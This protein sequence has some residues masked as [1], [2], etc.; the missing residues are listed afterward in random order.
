[1]A[2]DVRGNP[3][4]SY[5]SSGGE[6]AWLK[7]VMNYWSFYDQMHPD[8]QLGADV[9]GWDIAN[10]VEK[11]QRQYGLNPT[12]QADQ[13]TWWAIDQLARGVPP[14]QIQLDTG[15]SVPN[16]GGPWS[17]SPVDPGAPG[18]SNPSMTTNQRDALARVTLLL[19]SYGLSGME[20]WIKSKLIGGASEA[21]ISLE[22]Y[23]QPAFKARFP[24]ID[25]RR[26]A[27]LSPVSAAEVIE[28]EQR[29]REIMRMAGITSGEF[30]TTSY[31]Q[32]LML[33]DVSA[34]E[35]NSRVQDG[36]VRVQSAPPE[37]KVAFGSY[38]GT[39]GD[40]AMAQLFLDP[41]IAVPELE[42]MA[43]TAMAGGI[44]ARFGLQLAQGI[45]REI[46]DTGASDQAIWQGFAALDNMKSIFRES[47]SEG[48]DLTAEGEGIGAVF[49]TRP[50][51]TATLEQR[52]N[53]RTSTFRGGGSAAASDQGIVG[54]GIAD[55]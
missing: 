30:T 11:F 45:A 4:L 13:A 24:V 40:A 20:E 29:G 3:I 6:V 16:P 47:I 33:A 8:A 27:G 10:A 12:G 48:T 53:S 35:L 23:E 44:G 43:S 18:A 22:L 21:E 41:N 15:S 46:A 50:G 2:T 51:D 42:K 36:L 55:S 17:G 9:Y 31:L 34:A 19:Q 37:V 28:Y 39:T 38:F 5:G 52:V 49:N 25:Q 26:A 54:L 32:N 1:M 7:Q 14:E